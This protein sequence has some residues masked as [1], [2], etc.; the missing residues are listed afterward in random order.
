MILKM[1][2]FSE[3]KLG[4]AMTKNVPIINIKNVSYRYEQ[5]PVLTEINLSIH[6]GQFWGVIGPNGSGK[7]TLL[8]LLLG[9]LE[10]KQ[11]EI[12]L[13]GEKIRAFQQWERIGYV[14]Q[15]A[16]SFN[17]GFPATV[18]E[19]VRS[20]L[21]K[22]IGLFRPYP[23]D[24]REKVKKALDKVEMG[25]FIDRNIGEL[26]GGQQQRVFI[27]RGI[28]NEP[29]ILI[30]D[31]PTVGL[32]VQ[33]VQSF[34]QLLKKLNQENGLTIMMVTHDFAAM[35]EGLTH[36]ALL[37]RQLIFAGQIEE[38]KMDDIWPQFLYGPQEPFVYY[39]QS[40]GHGDA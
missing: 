21:V 26:S 20:G 36:I 19:V 15:K 38:F 24:I 7:S 30:L 40:G 27:A 32:D 39:Q 22:K 4:D 5:E 8:K 1:K 23:K 29:D 33:R 14:S 6:S 25:A 28:I 12:E 35:S 34:Y 2:C 9:L 17:S 31:E 16:N 3:G 18:F 11:G 13:F 10:F 37:N